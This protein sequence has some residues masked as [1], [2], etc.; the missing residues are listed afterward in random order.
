MCYKVAQL[1]HSTPSSQN[2]LARSDRRISQCTHRQI[3]SDTCISILDDIVQCLL[4]VSRGQ[5]RQHVNKGFGTFQ[6][7][8]KP[9]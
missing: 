1:K 9:R 7:D 5:N 8:T 2:V 6:L 3:L 4:H